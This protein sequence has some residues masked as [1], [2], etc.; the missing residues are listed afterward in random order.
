M[1]C[2]ALS[3]TG[4]QVVPRSSAIEPALIDSAPLIA[5]CRR[6]VCEFPPLRPSRLDTPETIDAAKRAVARW[7]SLC[8]EKGRD[9]GEMRDYQNKSE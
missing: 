5:Q 4:C 8:I 1:L 2:A 7:R 9:G 3:L 6:L